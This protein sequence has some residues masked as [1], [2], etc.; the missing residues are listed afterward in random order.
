MPRKN[1]F[2]V[3]QKVSRVEKIERERV[4]GGKVEDSDESD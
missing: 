3:A 1:S 4:R 2:S